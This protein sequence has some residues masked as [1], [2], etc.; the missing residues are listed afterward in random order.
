[1][2]NIHE[3]LAI[4]EASKSLNKVIDQVASALSNKAKQAHNFLKATSNNL[5]QINKQVNNNGL[6]KG[7]LSTAI[8]RSNMQLTRMLVNNKMV[9]SM[10]NKLTT[11][12]KET[13]AAYEQLVGIWKKPKDDKAETKKDACPDPN[14]EDKSEKS[15]KGFLGKTKDLASSMFSI[16]KQL[17][18]VITPALSAAM[19]QDKLKDMFIARTGN[20]DVGTAMFEKY[21]REA[22]R[23]GADVNK[24][25]SGTLGNLSITQNSGQ[26][27]ELSRLANQ[28]SAFDPSG[29]GLEGAF[30]T[31]D[32]ALKG[33]VG[34]LASKFN[35]PVDEIEASKLGELGKTNDIDGFISAFDQLLEKKGMGQEAFQTMM[36]SPANK[37]GNLLN[38]VQN[39]LAVVSQAA[40]EAFSP[41]MDM[42]INLFESGQLDPFFNALAV[43]FEMFA[44]FVTWLATLIPPA[45]ELISAGIAKVVEIVQGLIPIFLALAPIIM[46]VVAALAAYVVVSQ[47]VAFA[48]QIYSTVL[49]IAQTVTAA[50]TLATKLLNTAFRAS[51]VGFV[52]S[53]IFGIVT[54]IIALISVTTGIRQA[55]SNAFGFI[56]DVAESAVNFVIGLINGFI[57]G[58]NKVGGFFANLLGIDHKQIEEIEV[59]ADFSGVKEA[60]QD[61]IENFSMDDLKAQFGVDK[62]GDQ[63]DQSHLDLWDQQHPNMPTTPPVP[64]DIG[65]VGEIGKINDTVDVASEDLKLMRELAEIQS[66][67]NFVTLTPTVQMSTG[68]INSG[69]D[70]D[71]I[72]TRIEQKLEEEFVTAAEGVYA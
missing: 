9:Q 62:I 50:V 38:R 53:L 56:V 8:N 33:D 25:L 59:R 20:E 42:L 36:D 47:L 28:M 55:F 5:D 18:G 54:A 26:L 13:A 16:G 2:A 48:T 69:Y 52:I 4:F 60:G 35:I 68:D 41:L 57:Q 39:Q 63:G 64:P 31:L 17:V 58:I 43:G 51:P 3:A 21:R 30:S 72:I 34:S 27:S 67:Q 12:V 11:S 44:S 7:I 37:W 49:K 66:I 6:A 22:L 19:E 15:K 32:S 10:Q 46:G 45:W 1:M 61:F 23:T 24:Y 40:L 65:R 71:K 14:G 29:T 70:V